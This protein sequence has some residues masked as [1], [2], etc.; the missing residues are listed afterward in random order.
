M[1]LMSP[2]LAGRFFTTSTTWEAPI[3]YGQVSKYMSQTYRLGEARVGFSDSV[4]MAHR[5]AELWMV[6]G[7]PKSGG[8]LI[9]DDVES[10]WGGGINKHGEQVS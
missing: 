10:W 3:K 9:R 4:W 1:S 2:A 7:N 6:G 5:D 8:G